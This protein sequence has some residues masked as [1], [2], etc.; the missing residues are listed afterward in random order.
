VGR[1]VGRD[2]VGATAAVGGHRARTPR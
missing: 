2:P 1:P